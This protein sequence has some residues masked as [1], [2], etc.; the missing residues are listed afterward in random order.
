M[1]VPKGQFE[2]AAVV[3]RRRRCFSECCQPNDRRWDQ[4]ENFGGD[5]VEMDGWVVVN[6]EKRMEA[7]TTI[8]W[9]GW[10]THQWN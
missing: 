2:L 9:R 1:E 8:L 3:G 6:E 5:G 7:R 4:N 10:G